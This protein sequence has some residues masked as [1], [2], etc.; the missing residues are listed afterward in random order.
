MNEKNETY[1]Q[2][3]LEMLNQLLYNNDAATVGMNKNLPLKVASVLIVNRIDYINDP[4]LN[5]NQNQK[6]YYMEVG[7]YV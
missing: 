2:K 7:K 6:D 1:K 4:F 5:Q 3:A